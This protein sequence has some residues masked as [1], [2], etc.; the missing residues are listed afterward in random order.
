[1]FSSLVSYPASLCQSLQFLSLLLRLKCFHAVFT[2]LLFPLFSLSL[3]F[4]LYGWG[5]FCLFRAE[6]LREKRIRVFSLSLWSLC[7]KMFLKRGTCW[8][9]FTLLS[10]CW[11]HYYDRRVELALENMFLH[12]ALSTKNNKSTYMNL[13][14]SWTLVSRVTEAMQVTC[15]WMAWS[16][17]VAW[18]QMITHPAC[19]TTDN[20]TL[21]T[22]LQVSALKGDLRQSG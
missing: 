9:I 4:S 5:I 7:F 6:T 2:P 14:Q 11:C 21:N 16:W 3:L 19:P 17:M 18:W 1:M 20:R 15:P 10:L 13:L 22:D 12:C 8:V